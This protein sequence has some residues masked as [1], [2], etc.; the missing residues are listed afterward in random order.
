M[1]T[2]K[3]QQVG[4][5]TFTVSIPKAWAQAHGLTA[6]STIHLYDHADGSVIIRSSAKDVEE[7]DSARVEVRGDAPKLVERALNAVHAIGFETVT[8]T[9]EPSFSDDQR[10]VARRVKRTLVGMEIFVDDADEITVRNLLDPANVSIQQSVVQL[11]YLVLSI[12]EEATAGL[13][14]PTEVGIDRLQGRQDEAG[15]HFRMVS[16]HFSRAL[17]SLAEIDELGTTRP[18]LFDLYLTSQQLVRITDHC[19]RMA[20]HRER[21]S[22]EQ[23]APVEDELEHV[24][25]RIHD[26]LDEAVTGVLD[27]NG[28]DHA[29][30]VLD[31]SEETLSSLQSIE[32][33]LVDS[34]SEID[35]SERMRTSMADPSVDALS[36]I[37][38]CGSTIGEIALR[39]ALR[40]ENRC[41]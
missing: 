25:T 14:D 20:R 8:L 21:M 36:G 16:R 7:L 26:L 37:I 24:S 18:E 10:R 41:G 29:H 31:G 19:I 3:L 5:G 22:A 33:Q 13:T 30:R 12:Q 17:I 11:Q 2:R 6:G 23:Y 35:S 38:D 28:I 9:S 32:S 40:D 4:G 27:G 39:A 34:A 1:E 15:R